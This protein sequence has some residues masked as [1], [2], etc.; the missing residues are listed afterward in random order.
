MVKKAILTV[1]FIGCFFMVQAQTVIKE[2]ANNLALYSTSKDFAL[3]EKAKKS[4]DDVYK[5]RKDSVS[6][7]HNL[8]RSMIYANLANAD[9]KRKLAYKK[10]PADEALFSL[11]KLTNV[12]QNDEHSAEIIF[13][14]KQLANYFLVRANG[15]LSALN[16]SNAL[17]AYRMVD[18]LTS[19]DIKVKH[20]LALLSER[21]GQAVKAESYYKQLIEDK[22]HALPDYFM[23]LSNLYDNRG[24]FNKSMEVLQKG[25]ELFPGNRD[26]LFKMI[27]RYADN[28]Q[29]NA[30]TTLIGDALNL[31]PE[32]QNLNYLAGFSYEYSGNRSLAE[33]YYKKVIDLDANNY[34][35][36]YSLGLLY[37]NLYAKNNKEETLQDAGKYL[38]RAREISPNQV[39]LLKSLIVYY[40]ITN[41]TGE[42]EKVKNVLNQIILN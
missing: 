39:N 31:D 13:I 20:N 25:R 17:Y 8:L 12:K 1:G 24:D 5:T 6:Y 4:I 14:R 36:N 32:N 2:A 22:E 37:L 35:A 34:D 29:Y 11:R 27:N 7:R 16:Y 26:M 30:V 38:A 9:A 10:D 40:G 33:G 18:S 3:L 28:G 41:D 42:A 15:Q 23:A 21:L 19:G